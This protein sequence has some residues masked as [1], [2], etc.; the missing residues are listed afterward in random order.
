MS[1]YADGSANFLANKT[2]NKLINK[3]PLFLD[4]DDEMHVLAFR[5]IIEISLS[6]GRWWGEAADIS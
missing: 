2:I 5:K 6:Q 1:I 4:A 3:S